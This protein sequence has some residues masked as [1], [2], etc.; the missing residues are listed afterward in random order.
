M[1]I[2]SEIGARLVQTFCPLTTK[3]SPSNS[4]RQRRLA[5][6]LPASGSLKPWHHR[7]SA[8]RMRRRKYFFCSSVPCCTS[9]GP[10]IERPMVFMSGGVRARA[11]SSAQITCCVNVAPWPPYSTGHA[12]PT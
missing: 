2:Q 7:S 4:A 5:R 3:S 10:M 1:K 6:S 12:S 11:I 8:R 9:V